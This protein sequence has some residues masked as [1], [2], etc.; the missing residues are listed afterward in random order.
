VGF[1]DSHYQSGEKICP[2][3]RVTW[4]G[5]LGRV[6]FVLGS[7]ENSPA[8]MGGHDWLAE[9]ETSGFLLEVEGVGLIFEHDGDEDLNFIKRRV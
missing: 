6:I 3:D 8:D 5:R 7:T 9:T 4:A 1:R 2:G